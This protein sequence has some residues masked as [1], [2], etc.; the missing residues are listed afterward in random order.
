MAPGYSQHLTQRGHN[1][2]ACFFA[3]SDYLIYLYWLH[4]AA[5][6]YRV[7]IH[8]YVLMPNHVHL[9]A[10]PGLEG[11]LSRMM[12]Y[13]G[14]HYVQ[15]I[16]RV[17]R[18]SGTLWERRFRANLVDTDFV[19]T[20]CCLLSLYRYIEL[21]PVRA[22]LVRAPEHYKWSSAADHLALK[23]ASFLV[24]HDAYLRLGDTAQARARAYR[25]L[26]REPLAEEVLSE[27]RAATKQGVPLGSERFKDQLE[28]ELGRRMRLGRPGRKPK[29][30]GIAG[31][32][33]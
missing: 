5:S 24:D 15:Y 17:Y 3:E 29:D 14:R 2:Q 1:R 16:N 4:R 33:G 22:G 18:R 21:N 11:G 8:A 32:S 7:S 12:Q 23:E 31:Q 25:D 27:I 20:Q 6:A 28:G 26:L 19:D 10:T 13:L 30:Q 9:L